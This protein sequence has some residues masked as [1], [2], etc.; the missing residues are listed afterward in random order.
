MNHIFSNDEGELVVAST[1]EI[2]ATYYDCTLG[3]LEKPELE[4]W[5]LIPD[6]ERI[7]IVDE[8]GLEQVKLAS[9]W[10]AEFSSPT[11]IATT[12]N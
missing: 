2:A 10:A 7:G 4:R 6:C 11:Q 8:T 12:Y 1:V 5:D 3:G 9:E